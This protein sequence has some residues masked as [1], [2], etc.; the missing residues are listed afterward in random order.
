MYILRF[1]E[2]NFGAYI[3]QLITISFICCYISNIVIEFTSLLRFNTA[4]TE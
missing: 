2:S 3:L 4:I 1:E